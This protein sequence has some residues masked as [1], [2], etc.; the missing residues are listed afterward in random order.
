MSFSSSYRIDLR[1]FAVGRA[2]SFQLFFE[3]T[4]DFN[5]TSLW[6]IEFQWLRF[7][8][9]FSYQ[10]SNFIANADR[11]TVIILC[12][13]IEWIMKRDRVKIGRRVAIVS[14][15]WVLEVFW[16]SFRLTNSRRH[17]CSPLFRSQ[18][19]IHTDIRME[20][21]T[22]RDRRFRNKYFMLSIDGGAIH[23]H[24]YTSVE[25]LFC[26]HTLVLACFL[27]PSS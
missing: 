6:L 10:H 5:Y 12:A 25:R 22:A 16:I 11:V 9:S 4:T 7:F 15:C 23:L 19:T 21:T 2:S 13:L 20:I 3:H 18:Y 17:I 24:A 14:D 26:V 27:C 1:K 8:F